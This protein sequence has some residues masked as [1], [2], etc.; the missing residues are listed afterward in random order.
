M[1]SNLAVFKAG[2]RES[3]L[4]FGSTTDSEVPEAAAATA[5]DD[6]DSELVS[7]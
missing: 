3:V 2:L 1:E 5:D 6:D 4:K 7:V